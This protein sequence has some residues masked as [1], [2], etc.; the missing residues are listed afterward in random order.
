[1]NSA[2]YVIIAIVS[3][4][5][6]I[7]IIAVVFKGFK[8]YKPT[9]PATTDM[10]KYPSP[11]G[12]PK[13]NTDGTVKRTP[14]GKIIWDSPPKANPVSGAFGQCKAYTWNAYDKFVPAFPMIKS[15]AACTEGGVGCDAHAVW[16][17]QMMT[18]GSGSQTLCADVDQLYVQKMSHY[19]MGNYSQLMRSSGK[20]V[21]N[22]GADYTIEQEETYWTRC[23]EDAIKPCEGTIGLIAFASKLGQTGPNILDTANCLAV[24]GYTLGT[25]NQ[26]SGEQFVL[27]PCDM[28]TVDSQGQPS[29]L[30][31]I[32]R[33][34]F[35]GT[36]SKMITDPN[37]EFVKIIHRPTGMM[38]GPTFIDQVVTRPSAASSLALYKGVYRASAASSTRT[39][40]GTGTRSIV[41][42]DSRFYKLSSSMGTKTSTS[43]GT[44]TTVDTQGFWWYI[45][46]AMTDPDYKPPDLSSV[47]DPALTAY[48]AWL[49][50][51][52]TEKRAL[53][54]VMCTTIG[55]FGGSC[56][57]SSSHPDVSDI[58]LGS[59]QY[60]IYVADPTKLPANIATDKKVAWTYV[61]SP[62]TA[63]PMITITGGNIT[64]DKYKY[65]NINTAMSGPDADR[66]IGLA[67]SAQYYD[68]AILPLILKNPISFYAG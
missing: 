19:C 24:T 2:I 65:F 46:P 49:D 42:P 58:H 39:S 9:Q 26:I 12:S 14:D 68:Y 33:A 52:P 5:I 63:P 8:P 61:T 11:W 28:R 10:I 18:T 38:V 34:K 59:A 29:Q 25:N 44:A 57:P 4:V 67:S 32:L 16:D 36:T 21:G 53:I 45:A 31:R 35:D 7:V 13:F 47:T 48:Y 51:L 54:T 20:C 60:L 15:I 17:T 23:S 22:D 30:F 50:S 56:G 66:D 1:M 62:S 64:V 6:I 37:G 55:I 27:Q 3:L 41:Y 40:T 43:T